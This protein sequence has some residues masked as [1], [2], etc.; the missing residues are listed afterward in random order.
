MI[1]YGG[2]MLGPIRF[3]HIEK[4]TLEVCHT[5]KMIEEIEECIVELKSYDETLV[6][7]RAEIAAL[8]GTSSPQT[9]ATEYEATLLNPPDLA[10]ARRLLNARKGAMNGLQKTL[11]S[12]KQ[13]EN[14][15]PR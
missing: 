11:E 3:T 5:F 8:S 1:R 14:A 13:V 6:K 12:K 7:L 10:K 2:A 9:R 4:C 15:L